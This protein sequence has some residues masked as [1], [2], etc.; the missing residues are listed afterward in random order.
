MTIN[1]SFKS[2]WDNFVHLGNEPSLKEVGNYC[3]INIANALI[4]AGAEKMSGKTWRYGD[5]S[6]FFR[7]VDMQPYLNSISKQQKVNNLSQIIN[8]KG[9]IILKI[10]YSNCSGHMALW[11]GQKVHEKDTHA[12]GTEKIKGLFNDATEVY[13]YEFRLE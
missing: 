2:V 10:P 1:L 8:K 6:L 7:I 3:A 13:F 9:I 11:N 12:G 5:K 4:K